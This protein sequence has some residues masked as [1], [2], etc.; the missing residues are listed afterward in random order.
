[1]EIHDK[2]QAVVIAEPGG[3][4]VLT[5]QVVATPQVQPGHVLIR[6]A[7]AG[8]NGPDISQRQGAYPP[9]ADASPLPG[10]EVSGE[11]VALGANV[12]DWQLGD[13]V[14]ALCN[15]GGYAEYVAVP[16]GQV[17]PKPDAWSWAQAAT[18]PETFFTI[19]QTLIARSGLEAGMSVLIHGGAGG[20]GAT[21]IQ[22]TKLFGATAIATVSSPEKARYAHE[23]G[24]QTVIDY[25]SEDFVE[26]TLEATA[27]K[28]ADRIIDIVGGDY[29]NRNLKAA[30]RNGVILQLAT[31]AGA[32]AEVNLG[33]ILMKA[34]TLSGSTLRPQ[35]PEAKAGFARALR[36]RVWPA[37]DEGIIVPPRLRTFSLSQ[38]A[39]AHRAMEARDHYGKIVLITDFGAALGN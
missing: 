19:Q 36:A 35:S 37:I 8:V 4:E 18:L 14:V 1:M 12:T 32:R 29:A 7:A 26:K 11:I 25:T 16:A 39:D 24:A 5:P 34:L 23:M 9:P 17:L 21:A 10:L 27:G 38:A 15:G 3:P 30:A 33:L 6:V 13:A 22:M 28:G 20:I 31:R 2:M